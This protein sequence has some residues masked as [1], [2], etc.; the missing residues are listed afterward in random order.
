MWWRVGR[1][2]VARDFLTIRGGVADSRILS[3]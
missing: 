2:P 1:S 3:F